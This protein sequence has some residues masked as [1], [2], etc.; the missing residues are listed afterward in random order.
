MR[1]TPSGGAL[2]GG[3]PAPETLK[4][5]PF[6]LDLLDE[7]LWRDGEAVPLPPKTFALLVYLAE[8]AGRLATKEELLDSIWSDV[9]VSDAAL[10][11]MI[12][13]LRRALGDDAR[14]PDYIATVHRRGYRFVAPVERLAPEHA[15][16]GTDD[17]AAH[18]PETAAA[19]ATPLSPKGFF[20]RAHALEVGRR[21][22]ASVLDGEPQ[23]LL[24]S[25]EPGIGK[26]RL[27]EAIAEE[28]SARGVRAIWGRAHEAGSQPAFWPW[29][30]ILEAFEDGP[31]VLEPGPGADESES[32]RYRLFD[33]VTRLLTREA[34]ARP[35]LLALDDLQW[36]DP[37]SLELLAFVV[38]ELPACPLL[39]T[40][41]YRDVE[42]F[43]DAELE[44][45]LPS[46][47]RAP[48]PC[49]TLRLE[50]LD[51]SALA[52]LVSS[53]SPQARDA[54]WIDGM[55]ART[56]GNPFF[57]REL[58]LLADADTD[59]DDPAATPLP[60]GVQHVVRRRL[61]LLDEDCRDV[62]VTA[63]VIG[64]EFRLPLLSA[65]AGRSAS[66]LLQALRPATRARLV[67]A[68]PG[69]SGVYA[70]GH[71]L[72]WEA[73]H[74]QLDPAERA[75]RH[76]AVAEALRELHG[77]RPGPHLAER[78]HHLAGA[79]PL[80]E[81]AEVLAAQLEAAAYA[82]RLLGFESEVATLERALRVLDETGVLEHERGRVT[83]ALARARGRA[84]Q[85]DAA[86]EA[87]RRTIEHARGQADAVAFAEAAVGLSGA[88]AFSAHTSSEVV[89]LLSEALRGV[90]VDDAPALG[91]R[92]LSA[93]A[94]Q[95]TWT[96][97]WPQQ[98]GLSTRAADL[99][100]RS[101]D[102]EALLLV[103]AQRAAMIEG[104]GSDGARRACSEEIEALA[105]ETG[106]REGL[107]RAETLRVQHA[108]DRA[109]PE[110]IDEGLA[111]LEA[112]AAELGLP[113]HRLFCARVRV[114]RA[115]WR[116]ELGRAEER[117]SEALA[118]GE[119]SDREHAALVFA[120][121]LGG[122]RQLQG[123]L[124]ELEPVLRDAALRNPMLVS[125]RCAL[126]GIHAE[127][128]REDEA[129]AHYREIAR[130]DFEV[131][132]RGDPHYWLILSLLAP[133]CVAFGD[134]AQAE[135]LTAALTPRRARYL[136]VPHVLTVGCASR[137]L[138]ALAARLGRQDEAEALIDEAIEVERRMEARAWLAEAL[139]E[140]AAL[141]RGVDDGASAEALA[142][143]RRLAETCGL[144]G[145]QARIRSL[146]SGAA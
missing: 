46:L 141:L 89:E 47:A 106:D 65:A 10:K 5:G 76:A 17:A 2:P 16:T 130:H 126:A 8:R 112:L 27:V 13:E 61:S 107:A 62:L 40:A 28:A 125:F 83:T 139:C 64:R 88:I 84:G 23:I 142:E 77:D 94:W 11:V 35:L 69:Q 129:R 80:C 115:C 101:G 136:T 72:L 22:V 131:V 144:G 116:G 103:L 137:P 15:R 29:M 97:E 52:E 9:H 117:L 36:A 91:A 56:H 18:A 98:E 26:T 67:D 145:V 32:A 37:A 25:G 51:R 68:A 118:L 24:V 85:R 105:R 81:P 4:F 113:S 128:G 54:G 43:P 114:M 42:L 49:H 120:A 39:L 99:A 75:A 12:G 14:A 1:E 73:I 38:R 21:A 110:A 45:L 6:R 87:W 31:G 138:A 30:R 3:A 63:A 59:A 127:A 34:A 140:R 122:L 123:R 143:A 82:H 134:E 41:T 74:E 19:E 146:E 53:M 20:G 124:V 33:R 108:I 119:R 135:W 111:R 121:Q 132:R 100:R 92:V 102:R 96:P 58:L 93:L 57:A 70:F 104:H 44:R 66:E 78:A 109:D 79:L 50:G 71:P 90:S 55:L 86:A 133:L 60:A 95:L 48:L 7:R